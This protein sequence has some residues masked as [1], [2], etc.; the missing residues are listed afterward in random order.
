MVPSALAPLQLP[1]DGCR[2]P[3]GP[4]RPWRRW[5]RERDGERRV[6]I[7]VGGRRHK[8]PPRS[9]SM[10]TDACLSSDSLR[11]AGRYAAFRRAAARLGRARGFQRRPPP[12]PSREKKLHR[13]RAFLAALAGRSPS[14]ARRVHRHRVAGAI[15]RRRG[16]V[17]AWPRSCPAALQHRR[18]SRPRVPR[19]VHRWGV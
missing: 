17:R 12:S 13:G 2:G 5:V 19:S 10:A 7:G 4:W 9:T 18:A 1:R 15:G 6:V 8:Q 14:R 3:C 11:P 16:I